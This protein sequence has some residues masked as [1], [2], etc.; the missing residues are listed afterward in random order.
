MQPSRHAAGATSG[1]HI[2]TIALS[3]GQ[4]QR[5]TRNAARPRRPVAVSKT[6][7][8]LELQ[9]LPPAWSKR[10]S[11]APASPKLRRGSISPV[12]FAKAVV[13]LQHTKGDAIKI[14]RANGFNVVGGVSPDEV[15]RLLAL[16]A[17]D[18]AYTVST[19]LLRSLTRRLHSGGL[20]IPAPILSRNYQVLS[21]GMA[22]AMQARKISNTPF[23]YPLRQLLALLLI[24]FQALMPMVVAAFIDSISLVSVVCFFTCLGYFALNE[25]AREIELPFGIGANCLPLVAYQTD[26]NSKLCQLLDVDVPSFGLEPPGSRGRSPSMHRV[27]RRL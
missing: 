15:R 3:S 10:E 21:D 16:P 11:E 8:N 18:R 1:T 17:Q 6:M 9:Q 7:P 25:V 2:D 14:R 24:V 23:P 26:F 22:A 12:G 4:W 20:T 19:W 27:S 13:M 5:P